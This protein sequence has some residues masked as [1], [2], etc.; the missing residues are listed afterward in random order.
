MSEELLAN[1]QVHLDYQHMCITV[2][3]GRKKNRNV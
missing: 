1:A 3:Q 2:K